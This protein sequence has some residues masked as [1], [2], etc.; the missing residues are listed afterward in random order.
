LAQLVEEAS[1][2]LSIVVNDA[3]CGVD[4]V[5]TFGAVRGVGVIVYLN[6]GA[7]G[8]GGGIVINGRLVVGEGGNAGEF[9]HTAV[10]TRGRRCHC[11]ATGCLE[12][13]VRRDRFVE[14]A[15]LGD[16]ELDAVQAAMALAWLDPDSEGAREI[17]RQVSRLAVALRSIVN[18]FNP[19]TVNHGGH[20]AH[21]LAVVGE[22]EFHRRIA[23]TLPGGGSEPEIV[24][25]QLDD[26]LLLI[27]AAELVFAETLGDPTVMPT[28]SASPTFVP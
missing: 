2:L 18:I 22:R 21:L 28:R 8:I 4:A 1:G 17:D 10:S 3:S 27:G 24:G 6:G 7:S 20:L 15:G 5:M 19:R 26:E 25:A 11:G 23:P 14:A 13:E 16:V 9:G 12:T